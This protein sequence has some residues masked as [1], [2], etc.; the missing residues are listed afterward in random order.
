[1]SNIHGFSDLLPRSSVLRY[2]GGSA[3]VAPSTELTTENAD[4]YLAVQI[5]SGSTD[6]ALLEQATPDTVKVSSHGIKVTHSHRV[7]IHLHIML[8]FAAP[9]DSSELSDRL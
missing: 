3:Q 4:Q 7:S 8:K 2:R 6:D 1:M 9:S 5:A